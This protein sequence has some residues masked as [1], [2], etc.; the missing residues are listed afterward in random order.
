[1]TSVW[2]GQLALKK[3]QLQSKVVRER[4]WT[5]SVTN[6]CLSLIKM[7]TRAAHWDWT[8]VE[9]LPLKASNMQIGNLAI[10]GF[11]VLLVTM[12][13]ISSSS[14]A[15]I[16]SSSL[17]THIIEWSSVSTSG[18]DC[19]HLR[20]ALPMCFWSLGGWTLLNESAAVGGVEELAL[21]QMLQT[22]RMD[23]G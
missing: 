13:L 12:V 11:L 22:S 5:W 7:W 8:P 4:R 21:S 19:F 23:L 18:L 1:M 9:L 17:G 16:W 20:Q 15:S 6:T 14:P 3:D 2:R 10:L